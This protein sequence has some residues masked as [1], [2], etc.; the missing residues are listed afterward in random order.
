LILSVCFVLACVPT[1]A[2]EREERWRLFEQADGALLAASHTDEATDDLGVFFFRCKRGSGTVEVEG[3]AKQD[4][5]TAMADFIRTEG[6]PQVEPFPIG[7]GGE[8]LLNLSY[9][10]MSGT[11]QYSF[12]LPAIGPAFDEFKRTGQLQFKVGTAVIRE[13]FKKGLESAVKFQAICKQ[14][15]K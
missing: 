2:N 6:Y 15:P 9:S 13:E 3:T 5:R 7:S 11:W 14:P 8:S 1:D 10:E 12:T 4:L